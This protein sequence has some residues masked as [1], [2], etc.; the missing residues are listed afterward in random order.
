M[1]CI[2]IYITFLCY[3]RTVTP[4][5]SSSGKR[6]KIEPDAIELELEILKQLRSSCTNNSVPAI[7]DDDEEYKYG[8]T[9]A[10]SLKKLKPHLKAQ[11]KIKIQQLLYDLEF[12]QQLHTEPV[13]MQEPGPTVTHSRYDPYYHSAY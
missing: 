10:L 8:R 1:A 13:P 12:P 4:L 3:F 5:F 11:A 2:V 9:V 7:S 6:R